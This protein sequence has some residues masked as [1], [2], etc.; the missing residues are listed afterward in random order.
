MCVHADITQKQKWQIII[1][2]LMD[3]ILVIITL[4]KSLSFSVYNLKSLGYWVVFSKTDMGTH[5]H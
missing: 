5:F 3:T 4:Q 2:F 1:S